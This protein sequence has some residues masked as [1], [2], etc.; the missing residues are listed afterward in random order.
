[1]VNT[2]LV[3]SDFKLSARLLDWRR[4]GKQRVEAYQILNIINHLNYL[5][6]CFDIDRGDSL[7]NY[8]RR[9]YKKYKKCNFTLFYN[10]KEERYIQLRK[11]VKISFDEYKVINLG[12]CNH[13][14]VRMW[15]DY[16]ECLKHYIN[17]HIDEWI[18]RGYKNTMIFYDVDDFEYPSWC[19]DSNFHMNHKSALLKK[20]IDRN[21]KPWYVLKEE[22]KNL[23]E[24]VDY[25]WP[26]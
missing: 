14:A 5:S 7:K 12:F 26:L 24:F 8:I 23:D 9:I 13:P 20:E 6:T 19:L 18:S 11:S 21:E 4:L 17:C 16:P 25:I 2:F 1:M 10:T 15:Y 3:S 22:F